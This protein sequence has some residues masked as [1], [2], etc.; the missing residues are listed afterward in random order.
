MEALKEHLR[1]TGCSCVV[2]H[3]GDVR[4]YWR[5]GVADLYD[6]LL[7]E[8]G[9]LSGARVADKVVG[10]GAAALMVA[11]GVAELYADTLSRPAAE[12]LAAH[13]VRYDCGQMVSGI[14]NRAGTGRCPVETLC[15]PL[16]DI[17]AM[18]EAIGAFLSARRRDGHPAAAVA[19]GESTAKNP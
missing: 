18:V 5:R 14:R 10:R 19:V 16:T 15:E 1:R 17:G 4:C 11:G 13:G 3:G 8:P 9:F 12:L 2:A 6:L 7:R